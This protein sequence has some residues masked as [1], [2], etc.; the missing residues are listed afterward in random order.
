MVRFGLAGVTG[1][2]QDAKSSPAPDKVSDDL[3]L[4]MPGAYVPSPLQHRGTAR[5]NYQS[6]QYTPARPGHARQGSRLVNRAD[7]P[8]S[9]SSDNVQ[10]NKSP[11]AAEHSAAPA[12]RGDNTI[13]DATMIMHD[14]ETNAEATRQDIMADGSQISRISYEEEINFG[15]ETGMMADEDS[16]PEDWPA[17][18]QDL[19]SRSI[20]L[21]RSQARKRP[22]REQQHKYDL[23]DLQQDLFGRRRAQTKV[24]ERRF[25][26]GWGR[27]GR[28]IK[29][30]G[31]RISLISTCPAVRCPS[32]IITSLAADLRRTPRTTA[33]HVAETFSGDAKQTWLL[34]SALFDDAVTN[35]K[36]AVGDWLRKRVADSVRTDEQRALD[37]S[38]RVFARL[39]GGQIVE[40]CALALKNRDLRLA[41][42]LAQAGGDSDFRG[43]MADQL[44]DFADSSSL[45][46]VG[47]SYRMIYELLSGNTTVSRGTG[48]S[49]DGLA[50]KDLQLCNGLDWRRCFGLKLWYGAS[51]ADGLDEAFDLYERA[52]GS[53]APMRGELG[54]HD[55]DYLLLRHACT[56]D[57][58]LAE[59]ADP[60]A[61]GANL[62][63]ATQPWLLATYLAAR[64]SGSLDA[65]AQ[66]TYDQ[67]S[68]AFSAQ[69]ADAGL[70]LEA[71]A[72]ASCIGS[73]TAN[74]SGVKAVL[75]R[76]PVEMERLLTLDLP[77]QWVLEAAALQARSQGQHARVASLLLDAGLYNEAH[78]TIDQHIGPAAVISGRFDE[79]STLLARFD[80]HTQG[81]RGW[82]T[83]GQLYS[84]VVKLVTSSK[85]VD[86]TLISRVVAAIPA[87]HT[88]TFHQRVARTELA[89]LIARI[90]GMPQELRA[91]DI[92]LAGAQ[93]RR[94]VA[95]K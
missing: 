76:C 40:A 69:L 8:E 67:L 64:T 53:A 27:G 36:T 4:R 32:S 3:F 75:A 80:G 26:F 71:L 88:Q 19:Q 56:A 82:S 57:K 43:A 79:L 35:R 21:A 22:R 13:Q 9:S 20:L 77:R 29:A 38:E 78:R 62:L 37:T 5:S 63:D 14:D 24:E 41:T 87:M 15:D 44:A 16:I 45:P 47:T 94:L 85:Q 42:L 17:Q 2:A 25:I 61:G 7:E 11:Q 74:E 18:L 31:N 89:Q 58:S 49:S 84:D 52:A 91:D 92:E 83:C 51:L 10:N 60:R 72:V 12:Y 95:Q 34:T 48:R 28:G 93:I 46:H 33:A 73:K 1:D 68:L 65:A 23:A 54:I 86:R 30:S 39:T 59:L 81:V 55:I 50:G 90:A 70:W 66:L 6:Q